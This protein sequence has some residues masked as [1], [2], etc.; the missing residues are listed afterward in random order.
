MKFIRKN[1]RIIPIRDGQSPAAKGQKVQ[2]A[3]IT[4]FSFKTKVKNTTAGSR[5]KEG[6]EVGGWTG[7]ILGGV[8]GL[9]AG[10][11]KG[12]VAGAVIGAAGLGLLQGGIHAGFG[13]RKKV[14]MVVDGIH[15]NKGLV[16]FGK[17]KKNSGGTSV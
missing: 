15:T 8:G 1:G 9:S 12:A 7:G 17:R 16:K 13:S 11:L 5:F 4:G 3:K 6:A 2:K 10:G 14:S